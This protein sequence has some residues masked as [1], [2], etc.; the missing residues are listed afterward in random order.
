MPFL[1][2][3]LLTPVAALAGT[4][5]LVFY[6]LGSGTSAAMAMAPILL[7]AGLIEGSLH[8]APVTML[9]LPVTYAVLRRR[10]ALKVWR[11]VLAG[12]LAGIASILLFAVVLAS[13]GSGPIET[14]L[15][16]DLTF[17]DLAAI[18]ALS[19]FAGAV[20]GACFACLMRW[21]RP[22]PWRAP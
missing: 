17:A 6:L 11:L 19:S 13:L 1:V 7:M 3:L 22:E 10:S 18:T 16:K 14:G 15:S 20:A 21:L 5:V 9:A 12:L 4:L 8:A 2:G